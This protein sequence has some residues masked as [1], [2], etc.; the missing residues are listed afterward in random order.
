MPMATASTPP[1]TVTYVGG[2]V[3]ILYNQPLTDEDAQ[4]WVDGVATVGGST[5]VCCNP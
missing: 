4:A 5:Y 2:D 1:R 3:N